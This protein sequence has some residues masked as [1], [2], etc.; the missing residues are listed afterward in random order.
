MF[1]DDLLRIVR[2][3]DFALD[4]QATND[5]AQ[6]LG[7]AHFL[8][9]AASRKLSLKKIPE[10]DDQTPDFVTS[11]HK[12]PLHFEVK[13]PSVAGGLRRIQT[14]LEETGK[15]KAD[16][17]RQI[18][19]GRNIA[20]AM[21]VIAPYGY[22]KPWHSGKIHLVID[23]ILEKVRSNIKAGQYTQLNTFLVIDM[24]LLQVL[25]GGRENLRPLYPDPQVEGSKVSGILWMVAFGTPTSTIREF[26]DFEGETNLGEALGKCGILADTAFEF[27]RGLLFVIHPWSTRAQIW[28]LLRSS[29]EKTP[30]GRQVRAALRPLVAAAWNDELDGNHASL[31]PR[32]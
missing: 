20:M 10:M 2:T 30:S 25:A 12:I 7:E 6:T 32:R 26:A 5:F 8:A 16:I 19:A 3:R 4:E 14:T 24:S 31:R 21:N 27:I 28:G 9:L 11:R 29:D 1:L 13:T 23:T 15:A 22:P 17:D 18:A